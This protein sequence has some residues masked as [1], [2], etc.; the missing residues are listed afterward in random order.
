MERAA[1]AMRPCYLSTEHLPL[2]YRKTAP[3]DYFF[4]TSVAARFES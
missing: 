1:I 4:F 2:N 3:S